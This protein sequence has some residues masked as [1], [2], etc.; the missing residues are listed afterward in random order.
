[1]PKHYT[2]FLAKHGIKSTHQR[3]LVL[4]LL[5]QMNSPASAEEIYQKAALL[6]PTLNLSTIYRTLELFS[7]KNIVTKT[8]LSETKKAI[9]ELNTAGH[10]HYMVCVKCKALLPLE[11][12]PCALIEEAVSSQGGFE[13]IGHKLEI[14]GYCSRCK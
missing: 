8:I 7:S 13:I 3:N 10:K 4:D 12:C 5:H 14:M 2:D 9:Y 1:M 11:N 6:Q